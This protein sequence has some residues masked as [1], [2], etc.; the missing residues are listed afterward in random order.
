V[1]TSGCKKQMY[2]FNNKRKIT[3]KVRIVRDLETVAKCCKRTFYSEEK[4]NSEYP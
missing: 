3:D 2:K 1:T 4:S